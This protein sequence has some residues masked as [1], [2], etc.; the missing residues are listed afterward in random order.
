MLARVSTDAVEGASVKAVSSTF[1]G[2]SGW[3]TVAASTAARGMAVGCSSSSSSLMGR[4]AFPRCV[5]EE[6]G[7]VRA[8]VAGVAGGADVV[9]VGARVVGWPSTRGRVL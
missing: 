8:G 7:A 5:N 1:G 9:A 4:G 6:G 2:S 3:E